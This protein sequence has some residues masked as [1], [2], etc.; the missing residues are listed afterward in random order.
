MADRVVRIIIH[1]VFL[2]AIVAGVAAASG[3]FT[4]GT[5]DASGV[6][7]VFRAPEPDLSALAVA[8]APYTVVSMDAAGRGGRIGAPDLPVARCLIEVP[9]GARCAITLADAAYREVPVSAPVLPLQPSRPKSGAAPAFVIDPAAYQRSGFGEAPEAVVQDAGMLRGARL[10][11]VALEPVRYDPSRQVLR[12]LDTARIEVRFEDADHAATDAMASRYASPVYEALAAST[13]LNGAQDRYNPTGAIGFLAISTPAL[14]ADPQLAQ[15]LAW[16]TAKGFHVTHVSTDQTGVTKELIKAY[17]QNAYDNGDVP[18]TFVLFVGDSPGIPHWTGIGA[19]S[20]PT[21][22]NYA[23]LAGNDYLPDVAIGR[24][25]VTTATDLRSILAKTTSFEQIGWTGNN[26][27]EKHATFMASTD[28]YS[29]T[30]GTHNYVI[31]NYLLPRGYTCDKLYTYTYGATTQQV[32]DAI[33]QGRSQGTY[34]GHGAETSWADGPVFTQTDVRN[35]TNTVYPLIQSYA[36]LT[37]NFAYAECFGETWIR[38]SHGAVAFFGSSVT[39]YWTEDDILEKR[40]YEGIYDDQNPGEV[41]QTWLGG[42]VLYAKL[43]YYAHFGNIATTRRYFEM[44]NLLGD[45]SVDLWTAVPVAMQ[46]DAPQTLMAGQ[47]GME[48]N[49]V[50]VPNALVC[51]RK[52][53]GGDAIFATGWSDALG[54]VALD[55]G[56]PVA[57]G[58]LELTV[59]AHDRVPYFKSVQVIQPSGPYLVLDSCG[60]HD[61]TGDADFEVDAGESIGL[62]AF[63]ENIGIDGATNV[64]GSIA[65]SDANV[66]ILAGDRPYGTIPAGQV[67]GNADAFLVGIDANA[68]DQ[69][70]VA[71]DFQASADQGTW[72]CHFNLVIQSPVLAAGSVVI[73]DSAPG[74]NGDGG[75]DPGETVYAM[76]WL[77]NSGHAGVGAL[78]AT[79]T[80]ADP[81]IAIIDGDGYC[82]GVQES[83][84]GLIGS[85]QVQISPGCPSPANLPC[86]I[87]LA[88]PHGFASQVATGIAV[89]GWAD[90]AESDRGWQFGMAGD[91]ATSGIWLRAEPVGTTYNGQQAQ[92]E[93]DHTADPGQICFVT[94]NG[95]PGGAAGEADVDG[96]KTTLVSPVFDLAGAVSATVEYW[97]WYTNNLGNNGGQDYWDVDVT[98]DGTN[99]VHLEHTTASAN[100]WNRYTFDLQ[101]YI[102]LTNAVRIRF[103]AD[104]ASPGSLVEAAVDDFVLT[105]V[106][107]P[108]T[109]VSEPAIAGEGIVS[110]RPNPIDPRSE[111]V[112]RIDRPGLV[113]IAI[114]DVAGRVVRTIAEGERAAGEHRVAL[115]SPGVSG[116]IASGTYFLRF[117]SPRIVQYRQITVVR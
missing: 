89:G 13:V 57:P 24:L 29:V 52:A 27:W 99:W 107:A 54:H 35:L 91:T 5:D 117:E 58:T 51:A 77:T 17:I 110:C 31:N 71:F 78:S 10:V 49:V 48:F 42:M 90:N 106:R 63:L 82:P 21:D 14:Y 92:A 111:V 15:F 53:D 25:A 56:A 108:A 11:E 12:V 85:F 61:E 94:G 8:G 6:T 40:F 79:L 59:T 62:T 96:G 38:T 28:N 50:G 18:P 37:G 113:R 72:P 68:P 7:I 88:G 109:D 16:K 67:V 23:M 46:T 41:D 36:C 101:S 102:A 19:D 39:S 66:E 26:D 116:S 95:S 100:S 70:V 33:N 114:Y 104:D 87:G 112:F 98:G 69:H 4:L 103:V 97:R 3:L 74:G 55:F 60:I 65:T 45:A 83:G 22:L 86:A 2:A 44:Y 76:V 93:Y 47:T 80:S 30:E 43:K 84:Q 32:R 81:N 115:G 73:D 20:P 9:L 1:S 34:S 75:A 105:A 64:S